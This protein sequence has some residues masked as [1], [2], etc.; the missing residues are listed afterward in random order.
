[1]TLSESLQHLHAIELPTP[2][3]VGAVTVYLADAPGE[4]LTLIDTGPHTAE[5]RVALDESL[6]HLGHR[7]SDLA[8]I[9]ITHAHA[10][11]FGL[12]GELVSESQATVQT[13]AWNIAALADGEDFQAQRI[14]FYA[15]LMQQASV[16]T[17][18]MLA[19]GQATGNVRRYARPVAT[20]AT[21][22]EGDTLRMAG[23]D[24]QVLHTPGHS[25]G[26]IC[27]HDPA[28]RTLISS[29]HL[30]A[31]ISS[32]PVVEPPP[33]GQSERPR[34]LVQYQ[35][36]LLR[37]ASMGIRRALPGH[38]PII[39]DVADLVQQRM[40]FHQQ[41]VDRV[42]GALRQGAQ[43]TW[44]V[45]QALFPNL[46]PLDTFL[47]VSE[48]IGHLDLLE[49]EGKIASTTAGEVAVWRLVRDQTGP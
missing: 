33:P 37:V 28:T 6:E 29:D 30:L 12:A 17:E 26:L 44:E 32:N 10:D 25:A 22:R 24:W 42:L 27:L 13:H 7:A 39:R 3:P 36:S 23:R 18:I 40:D 41:R 19:M 11:H 1:M 31:D 20:E 2:F 43:T 14:L 4:P 47:A 45:T 8:R 48:V 35:R 38:G 49:M 34:S 15:E 21:V 5:A 9:I 16:P 46:S